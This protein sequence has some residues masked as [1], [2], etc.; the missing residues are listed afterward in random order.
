MLKLFFF[1]DEES[2]AGTLVSVCNISKQQSKLILG[3][4][5]MAKRKKAAKKTAKKATKKVAKKATRKKAAKKT[6]R[7]KK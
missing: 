1:V 4:D 6:T 5:K 2:H 3:G 7:K